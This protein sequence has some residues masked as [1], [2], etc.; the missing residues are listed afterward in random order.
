MIDRLYDRPTLAAVEKFVTVLD[1]AV[2]LL[3]PEY[4]DTSAIFTGKVECLLP[5]LLCRDIVSVHT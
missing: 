1:H 4:V 2:M 3:V 5:V